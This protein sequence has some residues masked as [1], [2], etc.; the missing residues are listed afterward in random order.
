[1]DNLVMIKGN[2]HSGIV[3]VLD[4]KADFDV[5]LE[6]VAERFRDSAKF[7]GTMKTAIT[8]DGRKLSDTE[9]TKLLDAITANSDLDVLCIIDGTNGFMQR[10][11]GKHKLTQDD[12]KD[13]AKIY[14]GSLRSG[15]SLDNETTVVII[16]DVNAGAN[17]TSKGSIIVLGSLKGNAFAG[18][19]GNENA[20]VLALE[21]APVQIRIAGSIARSPDKRDLET[22]KGPKIAILEDDN[23][24]IEPVSRSVLSEIKL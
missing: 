7:L 4:P 20:F 1:M 23:I 14:K 8:F 15:Q 18:C 13:Y 3:V 16:G 9:Q 5:L 21:M 11:E 19:D 10:F 6:K 22:E 2:N 17:V 12:L 24:Y